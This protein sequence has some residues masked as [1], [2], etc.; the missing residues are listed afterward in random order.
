MT[1]LL[2]ISLPD[3]SVR[4]VPRGSTPADIAAAIGPGLAKAALAA[5]VD[6]ELRDLTRP[7]EG[8][9]NLALVTARDEADALELARHDYAH[10]LAEAVQA[11]F[12][13]TQIT[14]GPSTDDG[15]YYDVKAPDG[16]EPFSM[17]DLPAIEDAMRAIIR[18]DKPLRRE[19]WSRE[20]L[21]AKWASEG[22]SFKAEW[23]KELPEGEELTVYW[24][25]DDWLDMCRGPHLPSTGKLDAEAFKLMRVSR[26][27]TAPAGSTRSSCRCTSR[28]SRKRPSAITVSWGARWICSTCRKKPTAPS[29]GTP[30]ATA[31]GAS[32]KPICAARWT[33]RATA[34]SRL[35]S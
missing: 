2:K 35:R 21:I 17:D 25:G 24:S 13:G 4:E 15:F 22:E 30:R 32:L 8:D 18:A 16:R 9:A 28:G 26:A 11:L 19:V 34:R 29:S 10:V 12:P 5:R 27:S 1:E 7:F 3:G 23:A 31:S 20:A 33:V 14:F 6:G